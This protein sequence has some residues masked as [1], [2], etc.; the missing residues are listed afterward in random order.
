M[1]DAVF[2]LAEVK[3]HNTKKSAWVTIHN[4]V[5][6]ITSFMQEHP[7]GEEVLLDVLGS[8]S[9]ESFED[10]G[11]SAD[12]RGLLDDYLIGDLHEDDQKANPSVGNYV[13][14]PEKN[15]DT[16]GDSNSTMILIAVVIVM[17]IG[18][19]WYTMA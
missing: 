7:G 4:K 17:L 10:V 18:A 12:A 15:K 8:D 6:D 16:S 13:W 11:H 9:T 5:Y 3:Q 1:S 19:A 14:Q 2:R